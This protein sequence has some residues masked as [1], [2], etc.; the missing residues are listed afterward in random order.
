MSTLKNATPE[1]PIRRNPNGSTWVG[2]CL[3][4]MLFRLEP[5]SFIGPRD[6]GDPRRNQDSPRW[7]QVPPCQGV[8]LA[9]YAEA[10]L[11]KNHLSIEL[12]IFSAGRFSLAGMGGSWLGSM[13]LGE[14]ATVM[15]VL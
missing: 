2:S 15:L 6:S 13:R 10:P 14:W 9:T 11:M 5:I 12:S 8:P 1:E 4:T 7:L 3:K